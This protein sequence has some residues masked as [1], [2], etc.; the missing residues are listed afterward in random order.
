M[1]AML[2]AAVVAEA[3]VDRRLKKPMVVGV[4]WISSRKRE[5]KEGAYLLTRCGLC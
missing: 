5:R 3:A 2:V 1:V 4:S